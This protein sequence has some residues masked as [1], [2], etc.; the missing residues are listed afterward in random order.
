MDTTTAL[1]TL[2]S[3]TNNLTSSISGVQAQQ[4][5]IEVAIQQLQGL[6]NTPSAD[7]VTAQQ[8][9]AAEQA[10]H[11][12]DNQNN[13]EAISQLENSVNTLQ[14]QL[15]DAQVAL[16]TEQEAHQTDNTNNAA[17][18]ADLQ[19]ELAAVPAQNTDVPQDSP[20]Q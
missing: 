13:T 11:A 12:S 4:A 14:S 19:K 10:A 17:T 6:L 15:T 1:S 18:I 9:L 2:Q 20:T 8:A 5:A 7:L 16:T 3:Y